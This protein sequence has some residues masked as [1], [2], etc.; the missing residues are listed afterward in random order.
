MK[1]VL[2]LIPVFLLVALSASVMLRA[3]EPAELLYTQEGSDLSFAEV[4]KSSGVKPGEKFSKGP[5]LGSRIHVNHELLEKQVGKI[6][7]HP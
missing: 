5:V 7:P 2:Q 6:R 3:A 4:L 1:R